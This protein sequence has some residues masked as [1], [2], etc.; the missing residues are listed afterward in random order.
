[1]KPITH[2][3]VEMRGDRRSSLWS[4]AIL[5][6]AVVFVAV[7]ALAPSGFAQTPSTVDTMRILGVTNVHPGDTFNLDLYFRNVDSLGGYTFRLAF[8]PTLV[9]PL[10]DT[11]DNAAPFDTIN[12]EITRLHGPADAL[13]E[14]R[15]F[16]ASLPSTGVLTGIYA[17]FN[18]IPSKLFF[19]SA[20]VAV[21]IR[22]RVL[23]TAATGQTT[24]ISFQN[25][26]NFPASFNTFSDWQSLHFKRPTLVSGGVTIVSGGGG[27]P[28]PHAPDVAQPASPQ[29]ANQGDL[30]TFNVSATDPDGDSLSLLAFNLPAGAQFTPNNPVKGKALTTGTFRW[31]P[32]FSQSGSFVVSFQ[33]TDSSGLTSPIRN[34]T[35]DV[36]SVPRDQLFTTSTPTLDPQGGVPGATNVVIP[37][38]FVEVQTVYGVQFDFLYDP[39]AFN[40]TSLQASSRLDGFTIY[41]DLGQ[42]PGRLRVVVFSVANDPI[43]SGSTSVLFNVIGNIP[44]DATPGAYDITFENA[45]EAINP[46]PNVSSVELATENGKVF[47]DFNGDV[48]VDGRVD[49][50]DAVHI[51]GYILGD[52]TFTARQFVAA[53]VNHDNFVDVFD[54]V[55]VINIIFGTPSF[56]SAPTDVPATLELLYNPDDGAHGAYYLSGNLPTDVAGAQIT[57]SFD[58]RK[59]T[60]DMPE[61]GVNAASVNLYTRKASDGK[62]TAILLRNPFI[63][64][65]RL[66]AGNGALLRFPVLSRA[67]GA[68]PTI[69][70]DDARL[71]DPGAN[72]IRVAGIGSNVPRSFALAQNYPNPFNAAT[73][74]TFSLDAASVATKAR[75]EIFNVLGQRVKIL[76]DGVLPAQRSFSYTWNAT[77]EDGH[78]V[79]SGVYFYRLTLDD[80]QETR[81]MVLLK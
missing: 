49:V 67:E 77:D 68:E 66:P 53:D 58:K 75:L 73:T 76:T 33:A 6:V 62:V 11:L 8:D 55:E 26:P 4:R 18:L 3:A 42:H 80:K 48:N 32:S 7:V 28:T 19:P 50:A 43:P 29:S 59:L 17:D 70:I 57:L 24:V 21:R 25:D 36:A 61:R 81:K 5:F 69:Y 38:D 30:L 72:P 20:A 52:F 1:M 9:G 64:G 63:D 34:V 12:V 37:V 71:A 13:G 47:V 65:S 45:F 51:V 56:N 16:N 2:K 46:D 78:P 39:D 14:T 10:T 74:I 60:L 40:P 22:F 15:I 44:S 31:T 27:G 41:D 79:A 54:L 23:P 35:I